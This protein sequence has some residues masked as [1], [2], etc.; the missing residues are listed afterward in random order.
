MEV[1]GLNDGVERVSELMSCLGERLHPQFV[2]LLLN[3]NGVRHVPDSRHYECALPKLNPLD[4]DL[5][6]L[7][8]LL[9]LVIQDEETSI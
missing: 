3:L 9:I 6:D 2:F 5:K 7:S 1:E 8:P 4:K